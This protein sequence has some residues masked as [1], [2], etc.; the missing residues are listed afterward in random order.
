MSQL[1]K[2]DINN[3]DFTRARMS[4]RIQRVGRNETKSEDAPFIPIGC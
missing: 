3:E 1:K 4:E 2:W